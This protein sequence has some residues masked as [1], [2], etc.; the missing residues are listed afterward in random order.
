MAI[1]LASPPA[2]K[3]SSQFETRLRELGPD[4]KVRAVVFLN[5]ELPSRRTSARTKLAQRRKFIGRI[6]ESS[7]E[8]LGE[9]DEILGGKRGRILQSEPDALG[10]IPIEA[11]ADGLRAVARSKNVRAILEDQAIGLLR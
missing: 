6:R 5:L 4:E 7:K 9:L 10:S 11:T 3:I 2:E 8:A 1:H